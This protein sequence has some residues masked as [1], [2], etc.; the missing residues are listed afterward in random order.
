[1]TH[2]IT[3]AHPV[4]GASEVTVEAETGAVNETVR[5]SSHVSSLERKRLTNA[6]NRISRKDFAKSQEGE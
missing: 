1:V 4:L 3:A 6:L 2:T 5:H